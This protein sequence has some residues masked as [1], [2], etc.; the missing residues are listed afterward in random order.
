MAEYTIDLCEGGTATADNYHPSFPPT[1]AF[2]NSDVNFWSSNKAV[3]T[4]IQYDFG[5]GNEKQIEK[6]TMKSGG[7]TFQ[8]YMPGTFDILGS[9][10][11][12]NWNNLHTV[13]GLLDWG[14]QEIREFIFS[15]DTFYQIYRINVTV[16]VDRQSNLII[17]ELEMMAEAITDINPNRPD[18]ITELYN[19]SYRG[20]LRGKASQGLIR[21][22]VK[23]FFTS[24]NF[25]E[26]ESYTEKG[27]VFTGRGDGGAFIKDT[28]EYDANVW[29]S[30]TDCPDPARN[31]ATSFSL[32]LKGYIV[33]GVG[34]TTYQD[35]DEY[36]P[37]TWASKAT[38]PLPARAY[39]AGT[40]INNKGYIFGG[41]S[42]ARDTDEYDPDMWINKTDMPLP[43]RYYLAATTILDKG[44]IFGGL[45]AAYTDTDE[46]DPDTWTSKT[47]I[48]LPGRRD[49][50]AVTILDKGYIFGGYDT[51]GRV[52]DCDEYSSDTWTSKTDM[53]APT[54]G[55]FSATTVLNK[56][57]VF[58]GIGYLKDCDEYDPDTWTS[59]ADI[60]LP[61]RYAS[62]SCSI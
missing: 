6:L 46:Y 43:G 15:N 33:G 51:V 41:T 62:T 19:L 44:Y 5:A 23:Q 47:D 1:I 4:W 13:S 57:Y 22:T 60:P 38:M 7:G 2:D 27:Y 14:E 61:G 17:N 18:N 59:K 35:C 53:P 58:G 8:L 32:N 16:N 50:C 56:G 26:I 12:T 55:R 39:L 31:S 28:D 30:K 9:N 49:H 54:R 10:D 11:G 48:P 34:A 37:D 40:D 21:P 24:E 45:S 25:E 42:N 3:P 20:N 52:A 36:S 29:V